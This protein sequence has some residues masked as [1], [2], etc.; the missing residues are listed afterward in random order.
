MGQFIPNDKGWWEEDSIFMKKGSG[1]PVHFNDQGWSIGR[2]C[3]HVTERVL[4]WWGP[5]QIIMG[6]R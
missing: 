3:F 4:G 5:F 2:F 6:E 1:G